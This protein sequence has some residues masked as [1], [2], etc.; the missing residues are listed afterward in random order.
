MAQTDLELTVILLSFKLWGYIYIPQHSAS[1][2]LL[3]ALSQISASLVKTLPNNTHL[4]LTAHHGHTCLEGA[5]AKRPG[6][7]ATSAGVAQHRHSP[8]RKEHF[9]AESLNPVVVHSFNPTT[10]EAKEGESL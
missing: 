4:L 5:K 9:S 1:A 8:G 7:A 2:A 3:T 10:W 6:A